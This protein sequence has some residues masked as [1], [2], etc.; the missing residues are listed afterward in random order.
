MD[1]FKLKKSVFQAGKG[2]FQALPII[3]GTLILISILSVSIPKSF[4][5]SVFG[6]NGF[7]NIFIAAVFGSISGG[8]PITSYIIGGELLNEG[9]A[10]SAV[11]A[12]LISWV[13]VGLIQLPA[14]IAILGKKFAIS[15]NLL[16]FIFSI[17]I[18]IIV[19]FIGGHYV[20]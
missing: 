16:S 20:F 12:F 10:L 14:E 6:N 11:T 2:L 7:F 15:R 19:A 13:T 1:K 4:Y 8:N 18:A 3:L 9:I 17:I 5:T